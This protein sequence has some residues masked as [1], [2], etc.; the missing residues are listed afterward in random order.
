[1]YLFSSCVMHSIV[2]TLPVDFTALI[3]YECSVITGEC[4]VSCSIRFK[5]FRNI[6]PTCSKYVISFSM[7]MIVYMY[8]AFKPC[9]IGKTWHE[10]QNVKGRPV[11][12]G[13]KEDTNKQTNKNLISCSL[14][15]IVSRSLII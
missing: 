1:L 13:R 11:N 3:V 10:R 5:A 15:Q 8:R 2:Q 6:T 14:F 9:K 4:E 12:V 7:K